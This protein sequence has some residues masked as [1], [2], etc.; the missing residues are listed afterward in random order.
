[1]SRQSKMARKARARKAAKGGPSFPFNRGRGIH[2]PR[3]KS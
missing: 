3:R 2:A 1:M